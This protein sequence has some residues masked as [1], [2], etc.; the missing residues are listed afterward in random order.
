LDTWFSSALWPFSTLGWPEETEELRVFYPTSVLVTGFDILFFWVAR[1]M[2]MGLKFMGAVPFKDVYIHALVRDI[3][4]RKM[5]KSRGNVIDPLVVMEEYGTDAFRFTLAAFA[6]QGRD[7]C[8]SEER[9]EGYRHFANKI[10]NAS[11]FSLANLADFRGI[12]HEIDLRQTNLPNRWILSRF[13]ETVK[14][15]TEA[16]E[17]YRFNEAAQAIYHFIWHEFCDWFLELIKPVLYGKDE[18][19]ERP[20]TQ[21]VLL[22][23]LDGALRLLHPFMPFITEEIWQ[24]L[25]HEGKSIMIA[26]FPHYDE[27]LSDEEALRDMD[28]VMRTIGGIRNIRGEMDIAPNKR[29][30]VLLLAEENDIRDGLEQHRA[31]ITDLARVRNLS[32]ITSGE[33]PQDVATAIIGDVEI[34]VAMARDMDLQGEARRLEKEIRKVEKDMEIVV[35]KLSNDG[36]IS[37]APAEVVEKVKAKREAL[38]IREKKLRESLGEIL[39]IEQSASAEGGRRAGG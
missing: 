3:Q 32:F 6:A 23:V 36:F 34:F 19:Q 33:R 14:E 39:K 21:Y 2:M 30:D 11:R 28:L 18:P 24:R 12:S 38:L 20:V 8:L 1:M 25:P 15:V 35:R 13:N 17:E 4:G 7:I 27:G 16:L 9:I 37:K 29:L 5:S 31:Y 10:W 22:R 26:D